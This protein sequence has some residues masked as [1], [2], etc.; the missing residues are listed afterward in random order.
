MPKIMA[1]TWEFSLETETLRVLHT[2]RQISTGF[3]RVNN[4]LLVPFGQ[5]VTLPNQ[6]TFP[7]LPYTTIPRFWEKVRKVDDT[8]L[9][10]SAPVG[11]ISETRAL[12]EKTD[13]KAPDMTNVQSSWQGIEKKFLSEVYRIIPSKRDWVTGITI[14]PTLSGTTCSFSRTTKPGQIFIYLRYD[15][16]VTSIAEAI[17]TSLTRDDVYTSLHGLW[18]ESELLTDWLVTNSSLADIIKP[19]ATES[20]NPTLAS[21]RTTQTA[22][23]FRQSEDFY[24][25]LG[26]HTQTSVFSVNDE[27][28]LIYKKTPEKAS[29]QTE[30]LLSYL[31]K[32]SNRIVT[33]DEIAEVLFSDEESFS[34]QA[35]AKSVQRLRDTLE[36]NGVSGSY[37]QTLRG[38]GYL[39]RN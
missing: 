32:N 22:K 6:V 15:Q 18:S 13:I 36:I 33:V 34:L 31:I 5:K 4:F 8:K 17:I 27:R 14:Y 24:Q 7:D 11:V 30:R 25:R 39:L 23:A 26:V 1:T 29:T 19:Y 2:A 20:F 10:I 3:Y 16:G 9:P 37:I 38:Q 35:I 21:I 28:P 12:L